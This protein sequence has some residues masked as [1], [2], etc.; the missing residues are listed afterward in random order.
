MEWN[1]AIGLTFW[2]I[3]SDR[4]QCEGTPRWWTRERLFRSVALAPCS[5]VVC[6]VESGNVS[7]RAVC[8]GR[9]RFRYSRNV[10]FASKSEHMKH[11]DGRVYMRQH[12][13]PWQ[14]L[15]TPVY[16]I[17]ASWQRQPNRDFLIFWNHVE[18]PELSTA[19]SDLTYDLNG[20]LSSSNLCCLVSEQI[21]FW[22]KMKFQFWTSCSCCF[23]SIYTFR[24]FPLKTRRGSKGPQLHKEQNLKNLGFEFVLVKGKKRL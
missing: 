17:L 4:T 22:M 9:M 1:P 10:W 7:F 11:G 13:R 16:R 19:P 24:H 15:E 2:L 20:N 14:V 21:C 18:A 5:S 23:Q 8:A 6:I 12:V 3:F